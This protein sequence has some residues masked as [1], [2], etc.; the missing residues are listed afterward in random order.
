[1]MHFTPCARVGAVLLA[2]A[3][4]SPPQILPGQD[5][6]D[7]PELTASAAF[8]PGVAGRGAGVDLKLDLEVKKKWTIYDPVTGSEF[9][10]PTRIVIN[11]DFL[12]PVGK[13]KFPKP[14][15]KKIGDENLRYHKGEF[16]VTWPQKIKPDAKPG[17][18]PIEVTIHYLA[19]HEDGLCLSPAKI[20]TTAA[21]EISEAVAVVPAED[22]AQ[23]AD[24]D[25]GKKAFDLLRNDL[26][27]DG[28]PLGGVGDAPASK[29]RWSVVA[30]TGNLRRGERAVLEVKYD[31]DEGWHIYAPLAPGEEPVGIPTSVAFSEAQALQR[32]DLEYPEPEMFLG[33]RALSHSGTI[34]VPFFPLADLEP[35]ET[36]LDVT[37]AFQTCDDKICLNPTTTQQDVAVRISD[38][39]AMA[40]PDAEPDLDAEGGADKEEQEEESTSLLLFLLEA[41]IWGL[42]TLLMPCTYPMIP[43]TISYF[44]K[45]AEKAQGSVVPM[46][47]TYGLGIVLIFVLIGV[48]VG[49]PIV[50][51]ATG[52][53]LNLVLGILFVVFALSLFGAFD[54]RLPNFLLNVSSKASMRGGYVGIFVLG[55]TLVVTSFTCTAPFVGALLGS[56][57][58]E[59]YGRLILGMAVFGA[60][61][62]TPFVALAL[63]PAG[64]RKLPKS[65]Q[66]MQTLKVTLGFVELAAALKFFSNVDLSMHNGV[67][68]VLPAALFLLWWS[69]LTFITGAYLLGAIPLKVEAGRS[70]GPLQM[71]FGIVMI[72]LGAYW[73][74]GAQGKRLDVISMAIAPPYPDDVK[75]RVLVKDDFELGMERALKEDLLVLINWTGVT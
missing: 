57:A 1:M 10:Y 11:A 47:L 24:A 74:Q 63:L 41:V 53:P 45:Q 36:T 38:A 12:E 42:V 21:L 8:S 33:Q 34:K 48:F 66:W 5:L 60:T 70:I 32:G 17:K 68:E 73:M 26:L 28:G 69:A 19:C 25:D 35:G 61:V 44:S 23:D 14:S 9:A 59:G 55:M 75:E 13:A 67:P 64:A 40:I 30:P 72:L 6:S 4:F 29:V 50:K 2:L 27:G 20:V 18:H 56:G 22:G 46:A 58:K 52:W 71:T 7:E 3:I 54:I 49:G 62:A 43:I 16:V 65:G 39:V 15:T 31:L 51:F 37:I